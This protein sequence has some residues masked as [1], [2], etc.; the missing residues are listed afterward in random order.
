VYC[1]SNIAAH[2]AV[3]IFIM[4]VAGQWNNCGAQRGWTLIA[5][6]TCQIQGTISKDSYMK[7]IVNLINGKATLYGM[8]GVEI[9]FCLT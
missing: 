2:V 6:I 1:S 7:L 4:N 9:L 5:E 8:G 3:A